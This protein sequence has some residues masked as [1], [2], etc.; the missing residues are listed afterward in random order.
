M[1][2]TKMSIKNYVQYTNDGR[3]RKKKHF[4][5]II[6]NEI[7]YGLTEYFFY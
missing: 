3:E 5:G 2:K 1:C 6:R 7:E 4:H